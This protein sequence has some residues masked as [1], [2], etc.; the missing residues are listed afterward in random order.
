MK[1]KDDIYFKDYLASRIIMSGKNI[2]GYDR[3]Y[4][5]INEDMVDEFLSIDFNDKEVL[6]VL[7]SSDQVFMFRALDAKKVDTFDFNRLT[8][9]YYFLR[10]WSIKYMNSLYPIL[11]NNWI[12]TLLSKVKVSSENEKKALLFF[13]KHLKNR[14]DFNNFFYDIDSQPEGAS[15]FTNA[16]MANNFV[17]DDLTFFNL[18]LFK[19]NSHLIFNKYDYIYISNILDWA[20]NNEEKMKIAKDNLVSY[21]KSNGLII[22]SNLVNRDISSFSVERKI[23]EEEFE[24]HE[25][26]NSRGYVYKKR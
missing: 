25:F 1:N 19:E 18:N 14:S 6:S 20:R 16:K 10:K 23:F 22:C 11:N 7:A 4:Y 24:F 3:V 13:K 2:D 21:L 17:D 26:P 5:R 9:Y 12:N 8:M 15:L